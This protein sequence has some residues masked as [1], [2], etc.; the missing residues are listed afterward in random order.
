MQNMLYYNI[1]Y[2]KYYNINSIFTMISI[3]YSIT[4]IIY[5]YMKLCKVFLR[6]YLWKRLPH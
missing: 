4:N 3:I 5:K 6:F 2:D 1:K